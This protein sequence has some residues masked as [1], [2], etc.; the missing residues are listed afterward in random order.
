MA[1]F[2]S[3]IMALPQGITF[4]LGSWVCVVNGL[5]GFDSNLDNSIEPEAI[6]SES[7]ATITRSEDHDDMLLLDLAKEIEQKLND[8]SSSTRT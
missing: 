4:V 7:H 5:G 3:T 6:S 2:A 1:T 8:N